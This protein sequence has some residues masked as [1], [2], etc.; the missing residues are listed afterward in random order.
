MLGR[1]RALGVLRRTLVGGVRRRPLRLLA[2]FG[3]LLGALGSFVPLAEGDRDGVEAAGAVAPPTSRSV[4]ERETAGRESRHGEEGRPARRR[5]R[6]AYRD[7]SKSE[8]LAVARREFASVVSRPL[9]RP[10]AAQRRDQIERYLG[11]NGAVVDVPGRGADVLMESLLP[12][13]ARSESG[14]LAPV[15]VGLERVGDGFEPANPLSRTRIS[16]RRPLVEFQRSEFSV[17]PVGSAAP[18]S[19]ATLVEGKLFYANVDTDTDFIAAPMPSGVETFH[20][21]RSSAS[22]QRLA[23]RF[24]LP[25]G[26]RLRLRDRERQSESRS[27]EVVRKGAALAEVLPPSAVDADG[28]RVP[29]AYE[30]VGERLVMAV[31]HRAEDVAYPIM[32]D[33]FVV[34]DQRYWYTNSEID[35]RGWEYNAEN[36]PDLWAGEGYFGRG[37]NISTWDRWYYADGD[38]GQWVFS[39]P[40]DFTGT[41]AGEGAYV[42]KMDFGATSHQPADNANSCMYMGLYSKQRSGWHPGVVW[43]APASTYAEAVSLPHYA[44]NPL[45]VC[46]WESRNYRVFCTANP[47]WED[48]GYPDPGTAAVF[49]MRMYG[50]VEN[51]GHVGMGSS[52]L[53]MGDR[54]DPHITTSGLPGGWISDG[55]LTVTGKDYGLGV[56]RL[57]ASGPNGYARTFSHPCDLRTNPPEDTPGSARRGDRN[58]RCPREFSSTIP[59]SDLP[60]GSYTLSLA[61]TDVIDRT[62]SSQVPV[63][64]D[65]FDPYVELGGELFDSAHEPLTGEDY[66]LLVEAL[67]GTS[68]SLQSGVT[69]IEVRLDGSRVALSEDTCPEDSCEMDLRWEFRRGNYPTPGSHRAE[70]IVTDGAGNQKREVFDF[71]L[72][73]T[74]TE[75]PPA[76]EGD[77]YTMSSRGPTAANGAGPGCPQT[78]DRATAQNVVR[79]TNDI[80]LDGFETTAHYSDGSYRV[81]YCDFLG[82]LTHSQHVGPV[83]VPTGSALLI[84]SET[85]PISGTS[86]VKYRTTF[87]TYGDP[88]DP[89]IQEVWAADRD[90]I[91][92]QVLPPTTVP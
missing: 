79:Y 37:L 82:T 21:L 66:D 72:S 78:F 26:A 74:R 60:E 71:V 51:G 12:L 42:F 34:E 55:S 38:F 49:G 77:A 35:F 36:V 15:G 25:P 40:G 67:D 32:V 50:A 24:R 43:R 62:I 57:S 47:C 80:R 10:P 28:V 83:V 16:A 4:D 1:F 84:A 87:Y 31:D 27:V 29:V 92:A 18:E 76:R 90:E 23:L 54:G 20:V 69:R 6:T 14:R 19:T 2:S 39:P 58:G 59:V 86:P 17:E 64:V 56:A 33:P 52:F 91:L 46:G 9:W 13:R 44:Q 61:A 85:L 88:S 68:T 53:F 7:Q 22:P 73:A 3:V 11:S 48:A 45:F 41:Y 81:A 65:R 8:A 63:K 75:A 30:L 89:Y 70:V 5:S